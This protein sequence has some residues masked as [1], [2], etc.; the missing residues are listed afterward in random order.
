MTYLSKDQEH[1]VKKEQHDLTS[2]MGYPPPP[3]LVPFGRLAYQS[4]CPRI[5][6][7]SRDVK[8]EATYDPWKY[9]VECLL[10]ESFHPDTIYQAIRRSL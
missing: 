6:T 7:F 1:I 8:S 2:P 5:F 3:P 9:E 4:Q 10:N